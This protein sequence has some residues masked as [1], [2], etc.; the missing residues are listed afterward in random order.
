MF[1]HV[2]SEQDRKVVELVISQ[3]VFY[4]SYIAPPGTT[5]ANLAILRAAFDR[6]VVDPQFLED[7]G[8][9]TATGTGATDIATASEAAAGATDAATTKRCAPAA[10]WRTATCA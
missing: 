9:T 3:T 4:R 10:C 2:K 7:A 1:K 8:P 5:P 6:T